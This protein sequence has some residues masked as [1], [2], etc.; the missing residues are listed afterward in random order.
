[1]ATFDDAPQLQQLHGK[2]VLDTNR[3]NDDKYEAD[4]QKNGFTV[5]AGEGS[6]RGRIQASHLLLVD[7][8]DSR[9]LGYID[10]NP[11]TYFPEDADNIIWF[12]EALK[13]T[14]YHDKH[15]IVL[16]HIAATTSGKGVATRLLED[17]LTR[18]KSQG[19]QHLFSIV[20][21]AP[22][23]N[24]ASVIWHT[25]NGFSRACVSLPDDLF[26]LKNYQSVLF[27]RSI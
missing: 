5:S 17:A 27:Y 14:H 16:H 19:Y 9:I 20:T 3:L 13:H 15:A 2:F 12:C 1:M 11:E 26:G 23:T 18:L 6:I 4:V 22:V 24:C 7:V 8:E 10:V 21:T 25:R